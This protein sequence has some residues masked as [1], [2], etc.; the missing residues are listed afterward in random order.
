MDARNTSVMAVLVTA[1]QSAVS[2]V[3]IESALDAR[4]KCGHDENWGGD[5]CGKQ[6]CRLRAGTLPKRGDKFRVS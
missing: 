1:I 2:A 6:A 5:A 4:N 3:E